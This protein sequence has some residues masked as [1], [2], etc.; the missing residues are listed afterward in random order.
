MRVKGSSATREGTLGNAMIKTK[1]QNTM[2]LG[3]GGGVSG[4]SDC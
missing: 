2:F 1:D 4:V 3:E